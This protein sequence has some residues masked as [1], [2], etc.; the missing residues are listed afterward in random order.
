[1]IRQKDVQLEHLTSHLREREGRLRQ[2]EEELQQ[3]DTQIQLKDEEIQQKSAEI[4]RLQ[5]RFQ[6]GINMIASYNIIVFYECAH[7]H[8]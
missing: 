8:T 4:S 6:V 7:L 1:M 3:K 2:R 5:R